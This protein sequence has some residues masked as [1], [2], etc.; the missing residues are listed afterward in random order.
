MVNTHLSTTAAHIVKE[1]F[2]LSDK[3]KYIV[4]SSKLDPTFENLLQPDFPLEGGYMH[5]KPVRIFKIG[6]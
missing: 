3:E 4:C 6:T 2:L 1:V 5:K